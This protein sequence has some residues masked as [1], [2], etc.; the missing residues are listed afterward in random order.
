MLGAKEV[1]LMESVIIIGE[2]G[3]FHNII[4]KI[5]HGWR[6]PCMWGEEKLRKFKEILRERRIKR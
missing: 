3:M 4:L 5:V 6:R 2:L 1:F